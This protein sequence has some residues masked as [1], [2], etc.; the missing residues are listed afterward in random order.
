M[1]AT[2][3]WVLFVLPALIFALV[4]LGWQPP[5]ASPTA[6]TPVVSAT[7][8]PTNTP[9]PTATPTPTSTGYRVTGYVVEFPD[10]GFNYYARGVSVALSPTGRSTTTDILTG[11]FVFDQVPN[12]IYTLIVNACHPTYGCWLPATV[13]V[14][15]A[16]V[17]VNLCL[18][19]ISTTTPTPTATPSATPSPTPTATTLPNIFLPLLLK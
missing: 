5:L 11:I 6:Q 7:P 2:R 17:H 8:S 10:C 19:P 14:T 1:P 12:G 9:L 4:E 13:R 15:D 16:N 18:P 3:A